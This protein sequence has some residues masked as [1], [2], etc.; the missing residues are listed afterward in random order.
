MHT[1]FTVDVGDRSHQLC[2]YPL[3]FLYREWAVSKEI[4]VEF[5]A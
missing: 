5:I 4:V 1:G 2:K 3:H